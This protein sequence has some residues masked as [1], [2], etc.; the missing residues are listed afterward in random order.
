MI[1]PVVYVFEAKQKLIDWLSQTDPDFLECVRGPSVWV[2][3]ESDSSLDSPGTKLVKMKILYFLWLLRSWDN[4]LDRLP[5]GS[6]VS[7]ATFD[8]FWTA[9]RMEADGDLDDLRCGAEKYDGRFLS[10]VGNKDL[11]SCTMEMKNG[12]EAAKGAEESPQ[13]AVD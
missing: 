7:L 10:L 12:H 9:R 13:I 8:E 11:D 3:Q 4:L 2:G 6:T 5:A 1:S